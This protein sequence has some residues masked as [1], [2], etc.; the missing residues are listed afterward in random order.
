MAPTVKTL[1]VGALGATAA[2]CLS[3][4]LAPLLGA[5]AA[6]L[7][8][9]RFTGGLHVSAK[10]RS[11]ALMAAGVFLGSRFPSDLAARAADWPVTLLAV[12]AYVA[13][14][15]LLAAAYLRL[16]ARY[17]LPTALFSAVPGGTP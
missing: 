6:V 8:A 9:G 17:D 5:L 7:L 11:V 15:V 4:P 12:P 2:I 13:A 10:T 1:A 3:L 16:A 14:A